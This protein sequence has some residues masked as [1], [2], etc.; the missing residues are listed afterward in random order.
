MGK[1][2]KGVDMDAWFAAARTDAERDIIV[3]ADGKRWAVLDRKTRE[4]AAPN[5]NPHPEIVIPSLKSRRVAEFARDALV[6]EIGC[7]GFVAI[8][9]ESKDPGWY[10]AGYRIFA[11]L[12]KCNIPTGEAR[13]IAVDLG[14][15]RPWLHNIRDGMDPDI[16]F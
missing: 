3:I 1:K 2:K 6:D 13:A 5:E 11:H 15:S 12:D 8:E 9:E 16:P 14:R 10:V 7:H 4:M